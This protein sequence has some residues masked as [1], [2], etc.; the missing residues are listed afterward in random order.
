[1]A[2]SRVGKEGVKSLSG[3]LAA[4]KTGWKGERGC[5]S[6][7]PI[8]PTS[9]RRRTLTTE[10]AAREGEEEEGEEED[11]GKSNSGG[12]SSSKQRTVMPESS[13]P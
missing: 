9:R 8:Q 1:M 3:G 11:G 4:F 7:S 5:G 12:H 10:S 13:L 2:N 6:N